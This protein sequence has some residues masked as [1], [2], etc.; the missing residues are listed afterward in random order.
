MNQLS[1][2]QLTL[3]CVRCL[4]ALGDAGQPLIRS[5]AEISA[6]RELIQA[7]SAPD[8]LRDTALSVPWLADRHVLDG[9]NMSSFQHFQL[10]NN[11]GY[12]WSED[13]CD[14]WAETQAVKALHLNVEWAPENWG[15]QAPAPHGVC[16]PQEVACAAQP[17]VSLGV[18]CFPSAATVAD[19]YA[20]LARSAWHEGDFEQWRRRAGYVLHMVQD[21]CVPAHS[22]GTLLLGH[23]EWENALERLWLQ[24]IGEIKFVDNT[25]ETLYK[26]SVVEAVKR[27]LFYSS[28]ATVVGLIQANALWSSVIAGPP[29]DMPD[30]QLNLALR[31][32]LRAIATSV[33][34]L[35]LMT[36]QE[37]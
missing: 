25:A 17:G 4:P 31:V 34:A 13:P 37:T 22:W 16:T 7:S 30:C 15:E 8:R 1:H 35:L 32:C 3:D 2:E 20:G 24:H 36:E 21:S 23:T 9:N 10:K 6:C 26:S 33:R 19:F 28:S 5:L 12:C 29:H 27:D 18:F 11:L 14:S